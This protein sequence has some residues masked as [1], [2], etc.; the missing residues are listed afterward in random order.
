MSFVELNVVKCKH[1]CTSVPLLF[2]WDSFSLILTTACIIWILFS[3]SVWS[4]HEI[5]VEVTNDWSGTRGQ[6]ILNVVE[7]CSKQTQQVKECW[8]IWPAITNKIDFCHFL[9]FG[10]LH[11]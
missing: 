10:Y 4:L 9:Y 5:A 11:G 2:G 3:F 6:F 1:L 7:L 8:L